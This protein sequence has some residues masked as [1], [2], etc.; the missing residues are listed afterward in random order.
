MSGA[1]MRDLFRCVDGH[2][3]TQA[4]ISRFLAEGGDINSP[5]ACG[6]TLLHLVIFSDA[7]VMREII[8]F[9][10][11]NGANPDTIDEL[12]ATPLI[13]AI[14]KKQAFDIVEEILK[15][16]PDDARRAAYINVLGNSGKTALY[17]AFEE[18]SSIEV[19]NL[20][21]DHGANPEITSLGVG[22]ET[23]LMQA[24]KQASRED[25]REGSREIVIKLLKSIPEE[26]K[27]VYI[28]AVDKDGKTAFH[29][30]TSFWGRS[31]R[32]WE[33]ANLLLDYGAHVETVDRYG[34]TPLRGVCNTPGDS[35]DMV[36][37]I[38]ASIPDAGRKAVYINHRHRGR[39]TALHCALFHFQPRVAQLL[40]DYGADAASIKNEYGQTPLQLAIS[41]GY[42]VLAGIIQKQLDEKRRWSEMRKVWLGG[43]VR[44]G[45]S[46][47]QERG[48]R[49]KPGF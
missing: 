37:R 43:V 5:D 17:K 7:P 15:R 39:S 21:L 46:R 3:L 49:N 25:A 35:F 10:L 30:I 29:C 13:I 14:T 32:G 40:L 27:A 24:V 18:Q 47:Q 19:I 41:R 26:R 8:F 6:R 12:G 23:S 28:N 1:G 4:M 20:L 34:D 2:S 48:G 16:I 33:L 44:A 42:S 45:W 36:V 22:G 38:L 9:L 11:K 31:P